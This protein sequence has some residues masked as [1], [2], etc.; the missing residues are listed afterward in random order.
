MERNFTPPAWLPAGDFG[1]GRWNLCELID[2]R[3]VYARVECRCGREPM[4]AHFENGGSEVVTGLL[5]VVQPEYYLGVDWIQFD[6]AF[7]R[8]GVTFAKE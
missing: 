2:G 5:R 3:Q 4:M 1:K 7:D 6:V 8:G